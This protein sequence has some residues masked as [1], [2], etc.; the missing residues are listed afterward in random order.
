MLSELNNLPPVVRRKVLRNA[1]AGL[2]AAHPGLGADALTN[3]A[4]SLIAPLIPKLKEE[5]MNAAK[6]AAE[7]AWAY[8]QPKIGEKMTGYLPKFALITGITLGAAVIAG[9]VIGRKLK[10][11]AVK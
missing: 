6:P 5:M 10:S 9:I 11:G 2:A 8:L 4:Y 7:S 3:A 1:M